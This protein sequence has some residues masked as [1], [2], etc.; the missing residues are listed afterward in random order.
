[1]N[2]LRRE[3]RAPRRTARR[4]A[5][6]LAATFGVSTVWSAVSFAN[7]VGT[8]AQN[9]N[10]TTSGLDFVTVQS[11]ETLEPGIVNFGLFLNYAVNSLPYF[12]DHAGNRTKFS[13][14]LLGAD[15]NVGVGLLPRVDFGVSAP[16]VLDQKVEGGGYH[17]QF[18]QNGNTEVRGNLKVRLLGERDGGLAVVGSA[19]VNR[20]KNNPY[21]GK[22]AGPTESAELVAD[23]TVGNVAI[24]VNFGYRWRKSG[25]KLDPE[26]P[27]SPLGDQYIASGALSY[28]FSSI[29]TKVI[30]EVFGSRP[31]KKESEASD[32]LASTAE[33]LL[34]L[35]YDFT[36]H[37]AGHVGAGTE[38]I[39]GRGSP[40]WRIYAGLNYAL[41]PTFA[42]PTEPQKMAIQEQPTALAKA[43]DPFAG[44]PKAREKIVIHDIL[45]EFDSDTL[46]IGGADN[47][48]AKLV[49]YLNQ[50]P[51]YTRL[52][53]EG[54]TDSI[55]S[56][57]YNMRLS[58]RRA[59]TIRKWLIDKYHLDPK[60]IAAAGRGERFPIADNGNYQGRQLNRRVEFIIFRNP[61]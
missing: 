11:S 25:E 19:A 43:Q 15:L 53:I 38:L 40:D 20:I 56:D 44:P 58:F 24:G 55:G 29:D 27:V 21:V 47:T 10:P 22:D 46:V 8:D 2:A 61:K 50:K 4:R 37:L 51:S 18:G 36:T 17:G 28:L 16:Q 33:A 31:A 60:K 54:H 42:K 45:F 39:H 48:L 57:D 5:A 23:T 1:M 49:N 7:V 9:F 41:G 32:R 6:T 30:A 14:S 12:D 26:L 52:I 34:G 13:D 35:K 3:E 59:Q